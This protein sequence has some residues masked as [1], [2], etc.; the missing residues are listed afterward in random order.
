MINYKII[1]NGRPLLLIHGWAMNAEVWSDLSDNL[2]SI[3]QVIS[4][5][6]RGHG[7]SKRLDGPFN[8]E[9]FAKDIRLLIDKLDLKD[10]TLIGWSM[11]VSVILKMLEHPLPSLI[12]LVFISGNPSLVKRADYENGIHEIVIKRLYKNTE[13]DF[14]KGLQNFH[15]LLFTPEELSQIEQLNIFKTVTDINNIPKKEAALESL[16]CLQND[17]LRDALDKIAVPTLLIHGKKDQISLSDAAVYM[18][19]RIKKSEL[20]LL[21]DTGHVPFITKEKETLEKIKLFLKTYDVKNR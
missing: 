8:Y 1:G 19:K 15:S 2:S 14:E 10:L 21:D 6:L 5:D 18:N 13:R 11:G 16:K 20:L 17:D 12:S 4:I 3:Y 9:I 7:K